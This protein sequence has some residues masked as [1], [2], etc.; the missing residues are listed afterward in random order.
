MGGLGGGLRET[1]KGFERSRCFI[2]LLGLGMAQASLEAS[3]AYA[4]QREQ[5]GKPIGGHQLVQQLIA[6]M[7][8]ELEAARLMVYK[9]LS[10]LDHG[11]GTNIEAAMAK[12]FATEAPSR[13]TAL[14]GSAESSRWSATSAARAD[15]DHPGRDDADQQPCHRPDST[16]HQRLRLMRDAGGTAYGSLKAFGEHRRR[17]VGR[18]V[19]TA[20]AWSERR[21]SRP[22][23]DRLKVF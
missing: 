16:R 11:R 23:E 1:M 17:S 4:Q 18:A 12:T 3:I 21:A 7:A 8:T 10:L 19:R 2:S 20:P 14:S 13:S 9:A 22:G 5:F 15:A 6:E